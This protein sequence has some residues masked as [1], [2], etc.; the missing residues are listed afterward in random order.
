MCVYQ[1][2]CISVCVSVCVYQCVCI[3]VC[4]SV[5]VYQCVCIS[6]CVSVCVYQCIAAVHVHTSMY[7]I[8]IYLVDELLPV[9]YDVHLLLG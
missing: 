9:T 3:S 6:M 2:V 1:C 5:C 7:I 4:V 8:Y